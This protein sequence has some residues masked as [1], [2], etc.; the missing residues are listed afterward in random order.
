M[1]RRRDPAPEPAQQFARAGVSLPYATAGLLPATRA[2]LALYARAAL[3]VL[4]GNYRDPGMLPPSVRLD[5]VRNERGEFVERL[6]NE[7]DWTLAVLLDRQVSELP[8]RTLVLAALADDLRIR[9]RLDAFVG[10]PLGGRLI[11][12]GDVL[13]QLVGALAQAVGSFSFDEDALNQLLPVAEHMLLGQTEAFAVVAPLPRVRVDEALVLAEGVNLRTLTA[14]E[15]ARCL[16][17]G[18]L[19]PPST[20]FAHVFGLPEG[21]AGIATSYVLPMTVGGNGSEE[22]RLAAQ[23]ALEAP[24]RLVED[25]LRALRILA[26]GRLETP[27][28]ASYEVLDWPG[29]QG[30]RVSGGATLAHLNT[31]TPPPDLRERAPGLLARVQS[32]EIRA[33]RRLQATMRRFEFASTR[34]RDDDRLVDLFIAAETFFEIKEWR[35]GKTIASLASRYLAGTAA[36]A[37]AA[38][39]G[40]DY[41]LRNRIVHVGVAFED[42]PTA[43]LEAAARVERVMRTALLL[44]LAGASGSS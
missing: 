11:R 34:L 36:E 7:P 4:A 6:F 8:E 23:E 5:W 22:Q 27:G 25:I 9:P 17:L 33:D 28:I 30:G 14:A 13:D 21:T 42:E 20:P 16:W 18:V 15:M 43:I 44:A 40:D 10:T 41:L 24:R 31:W 1:D 38:G 32:A 12:G 29:T 26:P 3:A 2:A 37:D 35:K 19:E 39:L